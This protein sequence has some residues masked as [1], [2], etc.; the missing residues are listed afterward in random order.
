LRQL[1]AN[2]SIITERGGILPLV[3]IHGVNT[4]STDADYAR[5]VEA[6]RM[7]F[8]QLVAKKV[9]ERYPGFR[10]AEDIYWGDLGVKFLWRLRSIPDTRQ[11]YTQGPGGDEMGNPDLLALMLQPPKGDKREHLGPAQPLAEA[12]RR[13]PA[14]LV[15]AVFAEEADRFAPPLFAPD[16]SGKETVSPES[17]VAQGENLGLLLIAID[18]F[19]RKAAEQP[20]LIQGATDQEVLDLIQSG[21]DDAYR[22]TFEAARADRAKIVEGKEHLGKISDGIGWTLNYLKTTIQDAR[23]SLAK[24]ATAAGREASLELSRRFRDPLSRKG[25]RF[26]GDVFV[27]LHHGIKQQDGGDRESIYD[28][29]RTKL[30]AL[31]QG[32]KKEPLV[33]VT[34]SF[35][36]EILYDLSTSGGLTELNDID[37][38]V[39]VG[40]QTALFAEMRLF[41]WMTKEIPEN[42][43]AF[44][45]GLP[46]KVLNW[47]NFYDPAD[48]LS[49]LHGPVFGNVKD[50]AVDDEG[51]LKNAHGHYFVTTSFYEGVLQEIQEV[52][53]KCPETK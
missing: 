7:M 15:R 1:N 35:G 44:T 20:N 17:A 30:L 28:R 48:V 19:A 18:R 12:A 31:K 25:L 33:V 39:T 50:V 14:G 49:Y 5:C 16:Q 13:D 41:K 24:L 9:R 38:W 8:D 42:T 11:K 36:S 34:H 32:E 2:R 29:V 52:L 3:F 10:V 22:S 26:L 51:N 23:D 47:V 27:Y 4:R 37:L 45:L 43:D 21:V 6:R 46:P 53:S 40:A